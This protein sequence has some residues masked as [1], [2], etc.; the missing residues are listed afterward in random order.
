ME[1]AQSWSI[2]Q[3]EARQ[4]SIFLDQELV[5]PLAAEVQGIGDGSV[6]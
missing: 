3:T 2:L 4:C 1:L 6:D 5:G